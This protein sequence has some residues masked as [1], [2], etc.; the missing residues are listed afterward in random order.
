MDQVPNPTRP[1]TNCHSYLS[2]SHYLLYSWNVVI[3][4]TIQYCPSLGFLAIG[5]QRHSPKSW[6]RLN[7]T[8]FYFSSVVGWY[9]LTNVVLVTSTNSM[10]VPPAM[11]ADLKSCFVAVDMTSEKQF[12]S[13]LMHSLK[14]SPLHLP[15][16]C[17]FLSLCPSRDNE[18]APPYLN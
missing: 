8:Y 13:Y 12:N 1:T 2:I 14:V 11:L 10:Y 17:I 18:L 3:Q 5:Q 6:W 4:K 15:I 9:S 7:H 16:F